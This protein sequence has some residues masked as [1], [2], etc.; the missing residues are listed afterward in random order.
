M[1]Y[2]PNAFLAKARH[3]W[4]SNEKHNPGQPMHWSKDKS[5]GDGNQVMRHLIEAM[6]A[7]SCGDTHAA[8]YHLTA[9]SWRADELLERFLA[10]NDPA[11]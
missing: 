2:F 11:I 6:E 10:K 5:I 4:E 3:S 9:T 8:Q 1:M 7:M